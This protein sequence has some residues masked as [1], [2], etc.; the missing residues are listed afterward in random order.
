VER[1]FGATL[2]AHCAYH[3][4]IH[5]IFARLHG[6][7]LPVRCFGRLF[8]GRFLAARFVLRPATNA[9]KRALIFLMEDLKTRIKEMIVE[10][11]FLPVEPSQI[12]DDE[13][14]METYGVDSVSLLELAIGMEE[15][16]GVSMEDADFNV[17][18]F[19]TVN[20]IAQFIQSKS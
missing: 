17:A 16:F 2:L 11:L 15:D 1:A 5:R 14:L 10:R 8:D 4:R 13:P 9:T 18:S 6:R 19:Q 20:S 12:S 3:R 7:P